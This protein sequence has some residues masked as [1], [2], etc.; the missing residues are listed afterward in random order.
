[1]LSTISICGNSFL[2]L[3]HLGNTGEGPIFQ[4]SWVA[5]IFTGEVVEPAI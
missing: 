3:P 2:E 1:M 4:P 5:S